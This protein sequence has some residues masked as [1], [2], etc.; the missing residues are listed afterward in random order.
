M[1]NYTQCYLLKGNKS[2][3]AWIPSKFAIID[4]IIKIKQNGVWDDGWKVITTFGVL[5]SKHIEK[6]ERDYVKQRLASDI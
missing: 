3:V 1:S 2:Q 5:P 6:H 4:K